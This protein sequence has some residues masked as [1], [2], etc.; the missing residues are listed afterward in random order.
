MLRESVIRIWEDAP[1]QIAVLLVFVE[2]IL[3]EKYLL[4]SFVESDVN[5]AR[6]LD[7]IGKPLIRTCVGMVIVVSSSTSF[8]LEMVHF[9]KHDMSFLLN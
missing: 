4:A 7:L 9:E 6:V 5:S 1:K 2:C 8:A 3:I